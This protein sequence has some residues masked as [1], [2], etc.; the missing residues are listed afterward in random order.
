[1]KLFLDLK[2]TLGKLRLLLV[3]KDRDDLIYHYYISILLFSKA[4]KFEDLPE[5][6]QE[7]VRFIEKHLNIPITWVGVGAGREEIIR[8]AGFI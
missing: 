2:K 1:M 7:F 4:T 3:L 8:K 6:A 5:N